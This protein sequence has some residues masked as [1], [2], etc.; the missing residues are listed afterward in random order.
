[1]CVCVVSQSSPP[2]ISSLLSVCNSPSLPSSLSP[3]PSFPLPPS[4]PPSLPLSSL[5]SLSRRKRDYAQQSIPALL[6]SRGVDPSLIIPKVC[7][8]ERGGA[9]QQEGA[10]R[11]ISATKDK[12]SRECVCVCTRVCVCVHVIAS[13]CPIMLC[14][15]VPVLS[16]RPS[17]HWRYLMTRSM[18]VALRRAG[19]P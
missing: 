1:M 4:I 11:T 3:P 2:P 7:R 5:P 19:W 18:T 14:V 10:A 17:C 13:A 8:K 15:Q 6:S 16:L 12:A 9:G